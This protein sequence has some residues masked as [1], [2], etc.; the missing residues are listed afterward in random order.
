M[1]ATAL[2]NKE[3]FSA[4]EVVTPREEDEGGA[5]EGAGEVAFRINIR[6]LLE[7]LNAYGMQSLVNTA[8]L[9]RYSSFDA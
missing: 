9:L 4:Y 3:L 2:L 5:G 1:F 6:V 8:V 7:C